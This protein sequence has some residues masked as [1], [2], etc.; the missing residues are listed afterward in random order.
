MMSPPR[1]R[2]SSPSPRRPVASIP[3]CALNQ[4]L[5]QQRWYNI[6]QQAEEMDWKEQLA[7]IYQRIVENPQLVEKQVEAFLTNQTETTFGVVASVN[8]FLQR[9]MRFQNCQQRI[10][11]VLCPVSFIPTSNEELLM[12]AR[13][14][15]RVLTTGKLPIAPLCSVT[16]PRSCVEV[17]GLWEGEPPEWTTG[18]LIRWMLSRGEVIREVYG[19]MPRNFPSRLPSMLEKLL[20]EMEK[21]GERNEQV[22]PYLSLSIL[23]KK[24]RICSLLMLLTRRLRH[25]SSGDLSDHLYPQGDL[26]KQA[27]QSI[28]HRVYFAEANERLEAERRK[29]SLSRQNEVC[30]L[31]REELLPGEGIRLKE[32]GRK[33]VFVWVCEADE[34]TVLNSGLY[35][36]TKEPSGSPSKKRSKS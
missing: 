8:G 34:E 4:D 17:E 30:I 20:M 36:R 28:S 21:E 22:R 5:V 13:S 7:T 35:N 33:G 25:H 10:S 32:K 12:R 1:E 11:N 23:Q 27:L 29:G 9:L 3:S 31:C 19:W 15:G 24:K 16:G 6:Q 18:D 2:F 14:V 26:S